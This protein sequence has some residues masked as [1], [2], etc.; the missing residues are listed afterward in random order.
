MI[1]LALVVT[2][3][4]RSESAAALPRPSA[5]ASAKLANSTVSQSQTAIWMAK[6]AGWP[7]EIATMAEMEASAATTS[8]AR[9]TGL[10]A[11]ARGSSLA[12]ALF[13]AVR[14]TP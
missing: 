2:R 8:V 6:S 10:P 5:I 9:I 14:M 1:S 11:S 3:V 4:A 12:K 13:R 7:A